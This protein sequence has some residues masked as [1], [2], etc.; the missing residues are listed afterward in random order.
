[1]LGLIV[2]LAPALSARAETAGIGQPA[3]SGPASSGPV[4][5]AAP[6]PAADVPSMSAPPA[7]ADS[8]SRDPAQR[9]AA[10]DHLWTLTKDVNQWALLILGA[11][12]AAILT[13]SYRRPARLWLR[14]L[15]AAFSV[16]TW[17]LLSA[18]IW[19]GLE[20]S[21]AFVAAK[22]MS[23]TEANYFQGLVRMNGALASQL[24]LFTYSIGFLVFWVGSFVI[25]WV[26]DP[27]REP[28]SKEKQ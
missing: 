6:T 16:I 18:T 8:R 20:S 2:W 5:P 11:T 15:I 14:I 17:M 13:T 25:W 4:S 26:I 27:E 3:S 12:I 19:Y 28:S 23:P 22:L 7:P 24:K 10:L 21:R 9:I 1:L